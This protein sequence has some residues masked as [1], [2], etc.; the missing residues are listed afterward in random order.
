MRERLA[1][2]GH[3]GLLVGIVVVA[4]LVRTVFLAGEASPSPELRLV[5][6]T[7]VRDALSWS[8]RPNTP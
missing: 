6:V 3:P 5:R 1:R 7:H 2:L 4:F 8:G